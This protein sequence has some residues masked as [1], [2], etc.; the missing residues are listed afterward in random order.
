MFT[1]EGRKDGGS[2]GKENEQIRRLGSYGGK[3]QGLG[4]LRTIL[5]Y[6]LG[7]MAL[8]AQCWCLI[9]VQDPPTQGHHQQIWVVVLKQNLKDEGFR[10][11]VAA[12]G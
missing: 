4:L 10:S 8:G 11:S 7:F 1:V 6:G 5:G 12:L 2:H 3:D 9:S